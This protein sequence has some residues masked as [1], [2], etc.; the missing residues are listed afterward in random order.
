[1]IAPRRFLPSIPSLL[2]LEAVDRLGAITAAAADLSLTHSAVSRQL[3]VLEEQ[4]GVELLRRDGRGV[5]LTDSGRDYARAARDCLHDLADASLRIRAAGARASLNLAIR[6]AFGMS[7]LAPRLQIYAARH[8]DISINLGTR[9]KPFDFA[10][11]RFDAAI[12][13]GLRDW[14]GMCWLDLAG[15]EVIPCCA[16]ALRPARTDDPQALLA[17]PLLHLEGRPGAWEDWFAQ[18][19]STV[20]RLRGML[21]DQ[22]STLAEA[23]VLG[24]GVALLPRAIAGPEIGRGR[25]V[26]AFDRYAPMQGRY[27]LVWP[28]ARPPSRALAALIAQLSEDDAGKDGTRQDR[29]RQDGV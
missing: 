3:N 23:A 28:E 25:L 20:S 12:H 1:M 2:A 11:E 14:P 29:A 21:F 22:F 17:L 13:F 19:G 26:A 8:P 10:Q 7:W 18:Q 24:F 9:L 15:E 5:A 6:P 27:A 16:P 4:L